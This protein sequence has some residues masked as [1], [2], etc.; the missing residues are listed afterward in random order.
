[1]LSFYSVMFH[2]T[3]MIPGHTHL[4]AV[5]RSCELISLKPLHSKPLPLS[6]EKLKDLN[7]LLPYHLVGH[8]TIY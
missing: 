3:F 2:H 4:E 7:S 1:M 6:E 5:R 8:F